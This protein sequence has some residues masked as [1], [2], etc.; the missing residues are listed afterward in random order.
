V[1][2]RRRNTDRSLAHG[3]IRARTGVQGGARF[4]RPFLPASAWLAASAAVWALEPW[5]K[6]SLEELRCAVAAGLAVAS[7]SLAGSAG[8]GEA[9]R[10]RPPRS[11]KGVRDQFAELD[12]LQ[13]CQNRHLQT[14]NHLVRFNARGVANAKLLYGII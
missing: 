3:G 5:I 9:G 8:P 12:G 1:A 10:D 7:G 4:L 14:P 6:P 2:G 11:N 13:L